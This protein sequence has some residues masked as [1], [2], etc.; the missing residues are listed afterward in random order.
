MPE[1]VRLILLEAYP[2]FG[3]GPQTSKSSEMDLEMVSAALKWLVV[4]AVAL[5]IEAEF[6]HLTSVAVGSFDQAAGIALS[7]AVDSD[8]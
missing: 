5:K 3:W 2:E 1:G 4:A 6:D 7:S 8:Q